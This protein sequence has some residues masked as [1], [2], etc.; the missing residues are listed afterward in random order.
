MAYDLRM[1]DGSSYVCCSV[2]QRV[3]VS[4]PVGPG[5]RQGFVDKHGESIRHQGRKRPP[6]GRG[7]QIDQSI[8]TLAS[9][10]IRLFL[11]ISA[12]ICLAYSSGV[13]ATGEAP[14]LSR[15]C[16]TPGSALTLTTAAYSLSS[17]GLG[18]LAGPIRPNP[19]GSWTDAKI[20]RATV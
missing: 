17:T 5:D 15:R 4:R 18:S 1:R 3:P 2:L 19:D 12:E 9:L 6:P 13:L 16:T 10:A 8:F 11:A 20:G 7:P 14:R